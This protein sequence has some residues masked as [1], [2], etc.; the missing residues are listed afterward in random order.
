MPIELECKNDKDFGR[1]QPVPLEKWLWRSYVKAAIIPLLVIE[2]SF[3][4]IYWVGSS[5]IYEENARTVGHISRVYLSDLAKREALNIEARL[6]GIAASTQLFAS[7]ALKALNG[8]HPLSIEERSRL[9]RFPAGGLY[10]RYDNGTTA[11]FYSTRTPIGPEQLAKVGR[12]S[13]L[14]P[15]MMDIK[16]TNKDVASL[17]F[18]SF[19]SYDRIYPYI[20]ARDQ[21][22]SDT[23]V[24]K[25]N[26][27]YEADA[28]HNPKRLGVWTDAYID[29]AG[30]G[31]LVSSI[32]PVW[33]GERLEGVVGIDVQLKTIIDRL[34]SL[35]LPWGSYAILVGSKGRIIAMPPAGERDFGL[36]ELTA[37][38]Y[39]DV[40]GSTRFKPEAFDI[41]RRKDT[42]PLARAI[43][44]TASGTVE[45]DLNGARLASFADVAETH[46]K[47]VI[48]APQA[49]ILADAE[50]LNQRLRTIG[51]A[52]LAGLFLFYVGFFFF[53]YR[54]AHRM[55][56]RMASPLG[57]I[58]TLL[59]S[60]GTGAYRQVF[61][62]SRIR[63]LDDLG[64][65]LA[66]TGEQ[67]GE[68]HDR[69]VA[70]ER[71]LNDALDHER[72][73]N[74]ERTQFIRTV[75]HELRTPLAVID[76]AAQIIDRKAE[77][78]T[79]PELQQR[80]AKV[81]GAVGRITDW[82]EKLLAT[83]V[84]GTD[85]AKT[86]GDAALAVA[87]VSSARSDTRDE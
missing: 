25:Y 58:M 2:I 27:Y 8:N 68:A 55:S 50:I 19:D 57:D 56:A 87:S 47:L 29:P 78:L 48:V 86:K 83:S 66:H 80:S 76:S 34:L 64:R 31:W 42:G 36:R 26:F 21:I 40:I 7:Q 14:D 70:Q 82:L 15:I 63:E 39:S 51:Y 1:N 60:I 4:I 69:I 11:S 37:Y 6:S 49:Q 77:T 28:A 85:G 67:L 65:R 71:R 24:T 62:G 44:E 23:D 74:E 38:K 17:Y 43:S 73:V 22:D 33:N 79:P 35:E 3:L 16:N 18:N 5:R 59:E 45:L 54:R 81:R 46:W 10:T 72:K 20:N 9:G 32:A 52:M 53:L 13:A 41:N 84:S 30:H 61:R 12:L 75:S